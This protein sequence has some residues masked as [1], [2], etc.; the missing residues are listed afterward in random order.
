MRAN[1]ARR[2][3]RPAAYLWA[4]PTTAVGL[5]AGVLTLVSGGRVQVERGALEFYG[6]FAR[7]LLEHRAVRA[8]A[9]T[10]GHVILGRD[11]GCLDSCRDHEQ[12]HVRQVERWGAFF[13]PAY[14]LASAW[15]WRQGRVRAI[16]R[17][18]D[19]ILALL[20]FEPPFFERAG[21][22]VTFVGHPVLESGADGGDAARFRAAHGLLPH[23]RV[24][25]VMP[26]SRASEVSRLLPVFGEAL[27]LAARAAPGLRPALPL[28][29]PVEDAVRAAAA[30]WDPAPIL[31]RDAAGKHDALAAARGNGAGLIK[32]GTSSLEVALAGVPMA[33]GYRVNPLTAAIARRLIT[34]RFA[35]IVNLLAEEAVI[36]EYL[37]ERCTP[38]LLA[39]ELARLLGDP[40][41]AE[42]QRRGAARVLGLLRPPGGGTPSEAAADA[43]LAVLDAA[44]P[45]PR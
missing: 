1:W 35:S 5:V 19:R 13:L 29:G 12:A 41:A 21:I 18:V 17:R 3:L 34:V 4:A 45:T 36:P 23:E 16:A 11:S 24:V 42:A 27:R 40:A 2:A 30:G 44:P 14:V 8:S 9:M 20:P 22:P 7:W 31:L 15:A 32:S 6:G 33:V 25:V 39:G 38:A 10:L 43:V 26:G 28:A 37:Q